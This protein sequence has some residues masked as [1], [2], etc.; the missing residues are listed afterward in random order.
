MLLV[1]RLFVAS[2]PDRT[3]ALILFAQRGSLPLSSRN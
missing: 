2:Y 1:A 3:Q